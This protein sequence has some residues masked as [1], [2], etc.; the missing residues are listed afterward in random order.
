M[1]AC[2]HINVILPLKL[3]WEPFYLVPEGVSVAVGDR[4][5][6][7]F[8]GRNYLGVVSAV[9][10]EVPPSVGR[11]LEIY[12]V[13]GTKS[14]ILPTEIQFW[15]MVADY[16]MCTVGEVYKA[17]Y[18]SVKD[19]TV[20]ARR[21]EEAFVPMADGVNLSET[22]GALT[23]E[24]EELLGK[25]KPLLV[26]TPHED[27]L[28]SLCLH[29]A[30][31]NILWLVPE[32]KL[33][34]TLL[35]T[36]E[37]V[38][39]SRLL[40]WDSGLTPARRRAVLHRMREG[41]SYILFG[42]RSALFLPHR[43]LGL[44][45]VQDE[46]DQSYKQT[47][48]APRYNG[49]DAAVMLSSVFG[50]KV[51]LQSASPSLETLQNCISGKYLSVGKEAASVRCE[52]V[53]I[54]AELKKNGMCGDIPKLVRSADCSCAGP[55]FFYKPRRAAFPRL[56]EL[57]EQ[58]SRFFSGRDAHGPVPCV[59]EDLLACPVPEGTG[60]LVVFGIDSMLGRAD[61]RADERAW[62]TVVQA[63]AKAPASLRSVI[64]LTREPGHP[65]FA[66]LHGGDPSFLLPER[67]EY[68]YPPFSRIVDV[69]VKDSFPDRQHRMLSSLCRT[70]QSA[71]LGNALPMADRVRVFLPR[72]RRLLSSKRRLCS[73]VGDFE[74]AG[75]YP[76]HI[77]FDVD[78]L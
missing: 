11:V 42:T 51:V 32:K 72:D 39:G 66:A 67:K 14:T 22:S 41:T 60:T 65:V 18:P 64:V 59:S 70:I 75:R 73:I 35:S 71:A 12:G 50:S 58:T 54:G 3:E 7:P 45:V 6:V 31:R 17:A 56:E 38:F 4:V 61:F 43:D 15:R 77:T 62:Q 55:L 63:L 53:D 52:I 69:L 23:I 48:P 78:P 1:T 26:R 24:A 74:R 36:L 21:K 29:N 9:D 10:S 28:M 76:S 44:I 25:G 37:A 46:Q 19:E 8:A 13:D 40:V 33:E 49:R 20:S 16:Y 34:K 27:V 57:Q 68:G 47:S 5:R 2:R 30:S